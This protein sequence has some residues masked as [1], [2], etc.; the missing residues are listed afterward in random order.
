[1]TTTSPGCSEGTKTDRTYSRKTGPSDGP[2]T[3]MVAVFPLNR[4]AEIIVVVH[5]CPCGAK[6]NSRVP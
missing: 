6:A 1:M 3:S 4:I 2:S 5:Q